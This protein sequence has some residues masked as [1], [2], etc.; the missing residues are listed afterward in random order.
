MPFL[1]PTRD[2]SLVQKPDFLALF[3]SYIFD[4]FGCSKNAGQ[5]GSGCRPHCILDS[6]SCNVGGSMWR[7]CK[8]SAGSN[9]SVKHSCN[10]IDW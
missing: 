1:W 8:T 7:D 9:P 2:F 3:A 6:I 10:V 4:V 5:F